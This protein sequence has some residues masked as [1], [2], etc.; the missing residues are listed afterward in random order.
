MWQRPDDVQTVELFFAGER[1]KPGRYREVGTGKELHLEKEDILPTSHD[2][3]VA[4]YMLVSDTW[5]QMKVQAI[6]RQAST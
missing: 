4:C 5:G 1:V 3:R 2:G 6:V